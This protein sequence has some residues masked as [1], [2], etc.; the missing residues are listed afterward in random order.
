MNAYG[1]VSYADKTGVYTVTVSDENGNEL[2]S[3]AVQGKE[4]EVPTKPSEP[5]E[6]TEPIEPNTPDEPTEPKEPETPDKPSKPTEPNTPQEPTTP[7]GAE[8]EKSGKG[9]GVAV[10]LF[11]IMLVLLAGGAVAFVLVRKFRNGKGNKK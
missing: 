8:T 7:N 3:F 6:P 9:N 1:Q 11:V 10:A 2:K 5:Q 4:K